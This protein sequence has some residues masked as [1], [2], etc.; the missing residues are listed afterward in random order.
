MWPD[1]VS[2]RGPLAHESDA[3]PTA[4]RSPAQ[5]PCYNDSVCYQR[6]CCKIEFAVIKKLD[7]GPSK[8]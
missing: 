1:R 4:L 2:N 5:D 8:A 3:L 7:I 6:F